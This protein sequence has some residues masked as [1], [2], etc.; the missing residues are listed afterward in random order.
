MNILMSAWSY[1]AT[2]ILQ[3]PAWMIGLIVLVGYVL[4]KKPWYDVLG[5]T[6]KAVIGY[7]IL[8]VG[9]SGLVNNFRPVLVGLGERFNLDAMVSTP[10]SDRTR[11]PQA[12]RKYSENRFHRL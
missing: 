7:M 11:L 9:S 1:F 2:N 5:G 8:A 3:Q 4:L 12:W 10:I 6:L